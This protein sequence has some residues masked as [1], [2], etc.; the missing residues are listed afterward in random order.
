MMK[1]KNTLCT[2]L[3]A[4]FGMNLAN[5]ATASII[6]SSFSGT[7]V[8]SSDAHGYF[9]TAG[10]SMVGISI[11][12]TYSFNTA[13]LTDATTTGYNIL[14]D[15]NHGPY[16]QTI[17]LSV[18]INGITISADSRGNG[19]IVQWARD[20]T[21]VNDNLR[22]EPRSGDPS[23]SADILLYLVSHGGFVQGQGF[24]APFSLETNSAYEG[25]AIIAPVGGG[26][27][28]DTLYFTQAAQVSAPE[29]VSLAILGIGVAG[30][31]TISRR[32]RPP[33]SRLA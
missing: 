7:I 16:P 20:A 28:F 1:T 17:S 27:G 10:T 13:T 21:H 22:A 30:I 32:A 23:P 4:L 11:F 2:L 33:I 14:A 6:S 24:T 3:L 25:I 26:A 9:G 18:T 31:L 12:G 29:P 15:Y 19:A 8:H 5:P